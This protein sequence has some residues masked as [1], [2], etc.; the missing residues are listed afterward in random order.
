LKNLLFIILSQDYNEEMF[1]YFE[2]FL[3]QH[4]ITLHI[5][6]VKEDFTIEDAFNKLYIKQDYVYFFGHADLE[7]VGDNANQIIYNWKHISETACL[8]GYFNDNCTLLLHCCLGGNAKITEQITESCTKFSTIVGTVNKH[9]DA[10]LI[11]IFS[12]FIY[13]IEKSKQTPK[14][15]CSKISDTLDIE[16]NCWSI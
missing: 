3:L 15:A 11:L 7:G 10:D 9:N 2:N 5:A 4:F 8:H 1:L 13:L 14:N 6:E 12:T 16:L